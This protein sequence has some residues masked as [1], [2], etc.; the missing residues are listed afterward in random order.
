[1]IPGLLGQDANIADLTDAKAEFFKSFINNKTL[2][3]KYQNALSG[4]GS[5]TNGGEKLLPTNLSNNILT[6]PF[7]K[8]NLRDIATFTAIKGLE[9]PKLLFDINDE[10]TEFLMDDTEVA[11]EIAT[12]GSSIIFERN[13]IKVKVNITDTLMHATNTNLVQTIESG[14]Q[15]ALAYKEKAIAF[16]PVQVKNCESFYSSNI[17]EIKGSNMFDT[18]TNAIADLD[19]LFSDNASV[20]MTRS[21]YYKELVKL[22]NNNTSLFLAPPERIIGAPVEFCDKAIVPVVGDFQYSHFNYDPQTVYDKDKDVETGIYK[23]V[24]TAWVDHK[25]KLKSAFRLI[26]VT[27][28]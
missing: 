12:T 18:V 7:V 23:F 8:N 21:D 26:K 9:I 2:D 1:M 13:K 25:I 15:S 22:A 27:P 28:E 5:K 17:K 14:L 6:E 24:L 4:F 20:V 10:N 19:D 11:K 16:S 3:K